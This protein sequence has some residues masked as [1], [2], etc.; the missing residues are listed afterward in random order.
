[1]IRLIA[2]D[3]DGTLLTPDK[4]LPEPTFALIERLLA[5]G[6]YFVPASGRQYANLRNFFRPVADRIPFLAENGALAVFQDKVLYTCPIPAE[7]ILP[8]LQVIRALPRLYPML[9]TPDCAYIEDTDQP[10][11]DYAFASYTNCKYLPSLN[12]VIGKAPVCKIAV[13]DAVN[14]AQNGGKVLPRRLPGLRTILSGPD[15]LDVSAPD[16]N[17]GAGIRFLQDY[18]HIPPEDCMAFGDHMN[19]FELLRSCK[20][21][22]VPENA[23]PALKQHFPNTVP[24]NRDGG[25]I[26]TIQAL[27]ERYG[28]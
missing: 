19:D 12:E 9:C 13:Y 3:L 26:Q 10:F 25:V 2:S 1:M 21:A 22:Y 24:S 7:Q 14:S 5:K 6:I 11:Y 15:W 18:L 4:H 20:H 8:A 28:G 23:F 16:A 27:L 17:K